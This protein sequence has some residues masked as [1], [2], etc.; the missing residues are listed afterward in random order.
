MEYIMAE[1]HMSGAPY[2]Y[3]VAKKI[4]SSIHPR[5]LGSHV[6]IYPSDRLSI[7]PRPQGFS[8][9]KWVG[10]EKALGSAGHVYSLNIPEKLIYMQ[11]AGFA[12]REGSSNGKINNNIANYVNIFVCV[13]FK[14]LRSI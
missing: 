10:R 13:R 3:S 2:M 4:W 8:V 11:P 12:L 14:S 1:A 7:Q 5:N 9:K 6:I